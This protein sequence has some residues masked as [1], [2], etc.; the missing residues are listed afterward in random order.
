MSDQ[1]F[2]SGSCQCGA[3]TLT[4]HDKPRMMV[5]CHCLDCQKATGTGHA[6]Y[7][8]FAENDV[9][10]NG[11]ATKFSVATDSGSQMARYFCPTC[12]GRVYGI[13][14]ER[15]GIVSIQVGC[16]EDHSWFST[17]AV[18][19]ASRRNDWDITS[20]EVPNFD[21]YIEKD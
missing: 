13:N 2:A 11:E 19:Y 15:P 21:H 12:G 7:A 14:S 9:T 17:Q 5:Q 16:F 20:D 18:V 3:I 8:M 10:I 4:T 1:T 6:S